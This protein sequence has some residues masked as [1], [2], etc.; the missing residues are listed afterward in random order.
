M[1]SKVKFVK[2]YRAMRDAPTLE[3][4]AVYIG[5]EYVGYLEVDRYGWNS[6]K[7]TPSQDWKFVAVTEKGEAI[8]QAITVGGAGWFSYFNDI[9]KSIREAVDSLVV[10]L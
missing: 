10:P 9:K 1:K 2:G 4:W 7:G 8:H 6:H 3:S 5:S